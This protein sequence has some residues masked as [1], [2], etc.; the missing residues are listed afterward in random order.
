VFVTVDAAGTVAIPNDDEFS[1]IDASIATWNNA[2]G[3]SCSYLRIMS[4]ARTALE[5]G[6]D[7]VNLIKFRDTTWGRPAS[8]I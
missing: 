1:I 8:D 4:D 7:G 2:G 6:S 3:P 5:V